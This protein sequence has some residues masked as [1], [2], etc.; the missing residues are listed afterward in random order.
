MPKRNPVDRDID[1]L[2]YRPGVGLMLL[3]ATDHVFVARRIDTAAE[4]W[5]MPQGGID[6]GE[7]PAEAALRELEEEIGTAKARIIAESRS[8]ISYDLPP[9][10]VPR[11]WGGRFRG[12]RQKWFALRFEGTDRDIDIATR[13][14]EFNAWKWVPMDAL[15]DVI[16]PFKRDIYRQ[17]VEEFRPLLAKGAP[18][19][20]R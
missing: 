17:V 16:V 8:W 14:P 20:R 13:H 2:P 5:Q 7:E 12:Q 19:Q 3:S 11:V 1:S 18:E 4:A 15:V 10:L 9:A 6:E